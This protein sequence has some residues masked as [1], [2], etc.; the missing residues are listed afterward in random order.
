VSFATS[1]VPFGLMK[2]DANQPFFQI[3]NIMGDSH[4][5]LLGNLDTL[6]WNVANSLWELGPGTI[7]YCNNC[8]FSAFI[9][10]NGDG[11]LDIV[12]VTAD[13]TP[14]LMGMLGTGNG[15]YDGSSLREL[16]GIKNFAWERLR[17]GPIVATDIDRDG[18]TDLI[19]WDGATIRV[20]R[21]TRRGFFAVTASLPVISN[22]GFK[23]TLLVADV[24]GDGYPDIIYADY[25]SDPDVL[26]VYVNDGAGRFLT[27][28]VLSGISR[29]W[30]IAVGDINGD[31]IPD[32]VVGNRLTT[33]LD[34]YVSQGNGTFTFSSSING[35]GFP[36]IMLTDVD[37][38]GDIDIVTAGGLFRSS[39]VNI[40]RNQ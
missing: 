19:V 21:Q 8:D 1:S 6:V 22:L 11:I 29:P 17:G 13:F 5:E 10:L 12:G 23:V 38:D 24:T 18:L 20:V 15:S 34:L 28:A 7:H 32:L 31:G 39:D 26:R 25:A 37:L 27:P 3:T 30:N 40:Y 4:P 9:D 33:N 16:A 36:F 35:V 2:N 14:K